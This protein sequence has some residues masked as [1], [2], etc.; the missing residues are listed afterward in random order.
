MSGKLLFVVFM[1]VYRFV[2]CCIHADKKTVRK[3]FVFLSVNFRK[4]YPE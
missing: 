2:P 1:V 4:M 3:N